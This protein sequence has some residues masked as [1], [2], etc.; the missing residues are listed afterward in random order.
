MPAA[1]EANTDHEAYVYTTVDDDPDSLAVFQQYRDAAAA[2]AFLRDPG[3]LQYLAESEHLL[4]G[5]PEILT[6]TPQWSK[7]VGPDHAA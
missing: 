4:A 6:C 7:S 2:A 3:Y 1:I 5:P